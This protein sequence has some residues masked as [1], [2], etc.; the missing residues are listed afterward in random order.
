MISVGIQGVASL[1]ST[2]TIT[3]VEIFYMKEE[4]PSYI[5]NGM[6]TSYSLYLAI[7]DFIKEVTTL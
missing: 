5:V 3:D 2:A 6:D 4:L 1:P 7:T